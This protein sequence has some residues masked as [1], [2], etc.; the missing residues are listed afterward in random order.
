MSWRL[1]VSFHISKTQLLLS[2]GRRAFNLLRLNPFGT[3]IY[4]VDEG[5][6]VVADF[7]NH[8]CNNIKLRNKESNRQRERKLRNIFWHA[9]Y[10]LFSTFNPQ[11]LISF[12][13]TRNTR[14][15]VCCLYRYPRCCVW[16]NRSL[17][18]GLIKEIVLNLS[19]FCQIIFE[20]FGACGCKCICNA[21]KWHWPPCQHCNG[22]LCFH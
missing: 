10:Q 8:H 15:C 1:L 9:T 16:R 14:F 19:S 3:S 7:F 20:K 22:P 13:Q 12:P 11:F 4:L 17:I 5:M 18:L 6:L 2:V 21:E